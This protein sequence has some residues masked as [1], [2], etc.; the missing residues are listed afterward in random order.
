M[1]PG[2]CASTVTNAGNKGSPFEAGADSKA[3]MLSPVLAKLEAR[4]ITAAGR[5]QGQQASKEPS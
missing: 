4:F 5:T 1:K 3:R 2:K